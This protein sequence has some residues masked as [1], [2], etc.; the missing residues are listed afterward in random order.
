MTT[1]PVA[2]PGPC[3]PASNPDAD[4]IARLRAGDGDAYESLFRTYAGGLMA[5]ARRFLGDTDD[6]AEAVQ[7]TFVSAFRGMAQF[8]VSARI[9]TWLHRI[10]V[11]TCLMK[12]RSRKRRRC[13]PLGDLEP[14]ARPDTPVPS[15]DIRDRLLAGIARLPEAYRTIIR[16][17]DLE[18]LDTMTTAARLGTN[19]SV[20]KTRLHRAR[21]ALRELLEPQLESL[22]C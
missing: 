21:H 4:L 19:E 11:N 8:E 15:H 12:L 20:V 10:A 22:M 13:L 2:V 7:D 17:R 1:A 3:L 16:L 14:V 6:A 9:G 18:G 5:V